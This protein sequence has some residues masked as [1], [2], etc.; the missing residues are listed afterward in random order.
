MRMIEVNILNTN[1]AL[2]LIKNI[3]RKYKE[4]KI[5]KY[6]CVSTDKATNPVNLMGASKRIM[7]LFLLKHS[8]SI[9]ISTA[10]FA[11][12]FLSNGSLFYSFLN[13][14]NKKQPIVI[15]ENINRYFIT[16]EESGKLCLLSCIFGEN[17]EIFFPKIKNEFKLISL[18]DISI[19]FL[20]NLGY[21]PY[22]CQ[23]EDE[24]REKAKNY[25][26][27]GKW[28]CFVS[29]N[30]TSGEKSFEEFYTE[31]DILN[32]DK[33]EDIGITYLNYQYNDKKL[34]YFLKEI[35]KLRR[36]SIY[37]K[38]EIIKLFNNVLPEFNHIEKNKSLDD[39]M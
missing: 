20:K 10:R 17:R 14:I 11:N 21:E 25:S 23:T 12:V 18:Y 39:K 1:K 6:F 32:L 3:E 13:R 2:N 7:E 8:E 36:K 35:E 9:S 28:P 37:D 4:K 30:D 19:K 24:A 27:D 16:I 38:N 29:K 33:F 15:P 5:K 22:F 26:N 31:K 34:F